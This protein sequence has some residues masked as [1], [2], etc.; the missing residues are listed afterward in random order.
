MSGL[1]STNL[2]VVRIL[3]NF[4][5]A[6]TVNTEAVPTVMYSFNSGRVGYCGYL[7][8]MKAYQSGPPSKE[9]EKIHPITF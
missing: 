6:F 9:M 3:C 4:Q 2:N 8:I 7:V 1:L 5:R